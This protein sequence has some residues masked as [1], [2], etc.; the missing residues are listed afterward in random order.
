MFTVTVI[1]SLAHRSFATTIAYEKSQFP[2]IDIKI[3]YKEQIYRG[4]LAFAVIVMNSNVS[5]ESSE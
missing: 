5:P 2:T 1:R 3:Q 4:T